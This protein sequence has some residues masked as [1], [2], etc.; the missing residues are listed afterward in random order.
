MFV[1]EALLLTFMTTPLVTIM[2]PPERRVRVAAT[3]ANFK[4]VPG[5]DT[6]NEKAESS[7]SSSVDVDGGDHKKTRFTVVLDKIDHLPGMMALTQLIQPPPATIDSMTETKKPIASSSRSLA[8]LGKQK[9]KNCFID[10]L[11]LIELSDR[12]SAVMKS[13]VADSLLHTDPLLGIFRMFGELNDLSISSSLSIVT[14]ADLAYSVSEHARNNLSHLILVPWLPPTSTP[15]TIEP[16]EP[17]ATPKVGSHSHSNNPFD[18]LF[19][20]A[21]MEKSGSAMHSHFIRGVFAQSKTDVALFIDHGYTPGETR[22]TGGTQHIFLPFFGGPDDRLALDFAVQLCANPNTSATVVRMVKQELSDVVE[23][24]EEAHIDQKVDGSR[25][26]T[27]TSV[28]A[29]FHH[30]VLD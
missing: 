25:G 10:A 17:P 16:Q 4:N 5:G 30:V 29:C 12:T 20:T 9:P 22:A 14:Y 1:L 15:T 2:Y 24:P 19:R 27:V 21:P 8:H 13:S 3:G 18:A 23:E 26:L 11:R 6:A 28:S 7:R